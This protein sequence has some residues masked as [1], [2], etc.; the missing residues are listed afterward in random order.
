MSGFTLSFFVLR[1]LFTDHLIKKAFNCIDHDILYSKMDSAGFGP[2]V[3]QWF[4]SYL[5]RTQQVGINGKLSDIVP[6]SKGIAQGTVLGPIL[7]IF[8]INDIFK[9]TKHV[10]MTLFADDCVMYLSG[11]N[12]ANVYGKIQADFDAIV[13]WTYRNSLRLNH[14]KTKAMIFSTRN[15][16]SKMGNPKQFTMNDHNIGF[17]HNYMYLGVMIDDVMSLVPLVK[18]VKKRISDK[19]FMLRKIRKFLTFEASVL[20]YKQTIL[21][22]IDYAG[23]LLMGSRNEDKSDVQILQ[24]DILRICNRSRISDRVSIEALHAKCKMVSLEQRRRKQ[25]L[26]LMY[27]LSKDASFL[28]VPG[29]ITRSAD[30]I[31]FKVPTKIRPVYERSPYYIGSLLWN[32]LPQATQEANCIVEFK[33]IIGRMNRTYKSM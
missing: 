24:N 20:V 33:K 22:I 28:H 15:K 19:I 26:G 18:S 25:L 32:E 12:W 17:V 29:R 7:F 16:I 10:K 1:L 27:L 14:D 31:V 11:N 9:C 2:L 5:K 13:D 4:K 3:I 30:K 23:F 6:V 8:Y 21:P